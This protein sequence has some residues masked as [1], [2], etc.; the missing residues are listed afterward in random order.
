M[1]RNPN[2]ITI[3]SSARDKALHRLKTRFSGELD[4]LNERAFELYRATSHPYAMVVWHLIRD[5]IERRD[6]S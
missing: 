6:A 4:D 3:F 5:A 1:K 2:R